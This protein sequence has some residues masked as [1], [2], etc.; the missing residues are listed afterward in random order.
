LEIRRGSADPTDIAAG[1]VQFDSGEFNYD[2]NTRVSLTTDQWAPPGEG[3][4][5]AP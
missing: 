3:S 1:E 4:P 2:K 5:S